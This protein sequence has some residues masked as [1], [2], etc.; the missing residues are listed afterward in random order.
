MRLLVT[1]VAMI[2]ASWVAGA[3]SATS[4]P[5]ER[6]SFPYVAEIEGISEQDPHVIIIVADTATWGDYTSSSAPFV[7]EWL[8]QCAVGLMNTRV[9]GLPSAAAAYLTLGAGSRAAAELDPELAELALNY[10]ESYGDVS[11]REVFEWRTGTKLGLA[12]IG[13]VALPSVLRE[14]AQALYSLRLGLLGEALRKAGL[15]AAAIGNADLPDHYRRQIAAI[16]MDKAGRVAAGDVGPRMYRVLSTAEPS[17][18]TDYKALESAFDR[19]LQEA[20]VIAVE[21][22]DLSRISIQAD[23]LMPDVLARRR[24]EAVAATDEFVRS[25]VERMKGRPWRLFLIT[26]SAFAMSEQ[27]PDVLT[28][29]AAWGAGISRGVLTSPSTR[30][31]GV[32]GNVDLAPSVLDFLHVPVPAEAIGRPMTRVPAP[33]AAPISYVMRMQEQQTRLE[34]N[35]PYVL[36]AVSPVIIAL[37]VLAAMALILAGPLPDGAAV[38]VRD[39]GLLIIAFPLGILL[40][41]AY[42]SANPAVVLAA[43]TGAAIGV[44]LMARALSRVAPPYAWLTGAFTLVVCIDMA[45]GQRLI[46]SSA[47]GYSVTGG[48]RYYGIGNELGGGLLATA[49]I[50]AAAWCGR[51]PRSARRLVAALILAAI[52]IVIGHPGAG[53][54]WGIAGPAALGFGLTVLGLYRARLNARNVAIALAA[55]AI[56]VAVVLAVNWPRPGANL[57]H[58]GLAIKSILRG[59]MPEMTEI[60][61]RRMARNLVLVRHSST[62]WILV[63]ALAVA[64]GAAMGRSR[65]LS[66]HLQRDPLLAAALVGAAV[67]SA[68]SFVVNDAGVAAAAWGFAVISGT[69]MYV[70]F[71]WRL[72]QGAIRLD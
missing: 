42:A 44:Y 17:V 68:L 26:P 67:A 8:K 37:F 64:A 14:N 40:I 60:F 2:L 47:L 29:I 16:V 9:Q 23:L 22:G 31:P 30:R 57:T 11:G 55:A 72:R 41:P 18:R 59:G 66:E 3:S 21:T 43:V 49:P 36:N 27:R 20:S 12:N 13:Y 61:S 71:D 65:A 46:Q 50:A 1:S 58:I 28:P 54:N 48:A 45:F 10:N 6:E 56:A 25:I 19:A 32:V 39:A 62:T 34:T 69:L 4:L 15:K 51:N 38:L 35:R 7:R 33:A 5:P 52:L 53:S 24:R 63:S 70:N